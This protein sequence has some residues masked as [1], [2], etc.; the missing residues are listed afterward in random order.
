MKAISIVLV[1]SAMVTLSGCS[2]KPPKAKFT[3]DE[4]LARPEQLDAK[5]KE[6]A[7]NPGDLRDD[8]DCVNAL[9]AEERRSQGSLRDLPPLDLPIPKQKDAGRSG[10]SSGEVSSRP[11]R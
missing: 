3:A 1:L 2:P 5:V 7:N 11:S 4:Y 10:S 6:C 9:T 8:P